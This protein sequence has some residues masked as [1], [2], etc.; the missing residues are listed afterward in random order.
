MK[1]SGSALREERLDRG[2]PLAA[3]A[4]EIGVE[5]GLWR[6]WEFEERVPSGD[7]AERLATWWGRPLEELGLG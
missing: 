7:L 4:R 2:L 3:A 6:A 5:R 1:W